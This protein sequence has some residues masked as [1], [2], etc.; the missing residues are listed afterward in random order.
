MMV[1]AMVVKKV[2]LLDVLKVGCLVQPKDVLLVVLR[3]ALLAVV[4][5]GYSVQKKGFPMAAPMVETLGL[6]MVA[7]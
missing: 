1:A 7:H 2:E 4:T 3:V 6:T 5:V